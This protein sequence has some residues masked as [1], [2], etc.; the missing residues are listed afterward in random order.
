MEMPVDHLFK[1]KSTASLSCMML[2]LEFWS[3]KIIW[4]NLFIV[5]MRKLQPQGCW[6]FN[7]VSGI[8]E[9]RTQVFLRS[10][11]GLFCVVL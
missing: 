11:S 3:Q 5:L 8:I 10:S 6:L 2:H 9:T 4:S 1:A 7:L